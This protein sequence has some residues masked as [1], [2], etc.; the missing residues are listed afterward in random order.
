MQLAS[1]KGLG[2]TG[3]SSGVA[4]YRSICMIFILSLCYFNFLVEENIPL[5]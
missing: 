1:A 2:D 4:L 5:L 3:L